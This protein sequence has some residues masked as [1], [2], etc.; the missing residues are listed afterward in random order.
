MIVALTSS[1]QTTE[2]E[3]YAKLGADMCISFPFNMNYLRTALE[4]LQQKQK[5]VSEYYKSPRGTFT[6]DEGKVIHNED[7]DFMDK[8]LKTIEENISNPELTAPMI[9]DLV[10]I[11]TRVMYRRMEGITEKKLH[12]IIREARMS[13]AVTLLSSS[14][15][16]ID[17]IMYKVGYDNRSTF[18]RNFKDIYGK[19]PREYREQMHRDMIR[20]LTK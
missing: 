11:S 19:T 7:K 2:R 3:E 17:E 14:K 16:N 6:I 15:L 9:A 10:G 8:I 4:K 1:L 12:Q 5:N 20:D 13:M 18:Y